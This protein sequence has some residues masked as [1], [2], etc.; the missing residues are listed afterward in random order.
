MEQLD[1]AIIRTIIYGDVFSF[2]MTAKEIHHFLISDGAVSFQDVEYR[3]KTSTYLQSYLVEDGGYHALIERDHLI[4]LRIER[5]QFTQVL[6]NKAIR[7][8]R[9]LNH[10]PF[11][12][13]VA[14]TGALSMHNPSSANDDL[15]YILI[16]KPGR[17]WLARAFAILLV[18]VL[19]LFKVEICP[20]YVLASD[21]LEQS[22]QDIYIAHEV[23][24]MLPICNMEIY[25][26]MRA[27]NP[28]TDNFL[29]NADAPIH[30]INIKPLNQVG[31]IVKRSLEA[32]LSTQIGNWLEAW[33]YKRK[34]QR[35]QQQAQ[36]PSASAQIDQGQVK[37]HF[38][39]YGYGV[40]AKYQSKLEEFNL[41][42]Y[43][44][45]ETAGD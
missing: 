44:A 27:K 22:R 36:E 25:V 12:E 18:Y 14:I 1:L 30:K 26:S 39:D 2:P 24:Q 42:E 16:T 41:L 45:L 28:W 10:F 3:L 9:L 34:S 6:M 19:R 20:N 32:I 33:E 21:Q 15:D 11:I 23:V 35:F 37:G 13:M 17:V 38:N 43:N 7:Y 29:P 4:E 8:G 5:E 31:T 40:L